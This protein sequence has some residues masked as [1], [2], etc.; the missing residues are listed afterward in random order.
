M[1]VW[2]VSTSQMFAN[3]SWF[4]KPNSRHC[5]LL[6]CRKMQIKNVQRSLN[7]W[8]CISFHPSVHRHFIIHLV[9]LILC[10]INVKRVNSVIIP[11][12]FITR[13]SIESL[14]CYVWGT[15]SVLWVIYSSS[16]RW[17]WWSILGYLYCVRS[18]RVSCMI[19]VILLITLY[20]CE[21]DMI[22]Y[23]AIVKYV[24]HPLVFALLRLYLMN[25]KLQLR[26]C[27]QIKSWRK[28]KWVSAYGF[29]G[30]FELYCQK[31]W[32]DESW[33]RCR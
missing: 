23:S 11:V 8:V 31:E 9:L 14:T 4:W 29:F 26:K 3:F 6:W 18:I 32:D 20:M 22:V 12:A 10:L 27:L 19:F 7:I 5:F 15:Y 33:N 16:S 1:T 17:E 13:S 24:F 25:V 21:F 2:I 30:L 28:S